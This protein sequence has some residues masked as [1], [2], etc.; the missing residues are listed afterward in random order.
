M[1]QWQGSVTYFM[2]PVDHVLS[3]RLMIREI[4]TIWKQVLLFTRY[5]IYNTKKN[6]VLISKNGEKSIKIICILFNKQGI[7]TQ[8]FLTIFVFKG[9]EIIVCKRQ[10]I[11]FRRMQWG[12]KAIK[13]I[14]VSIFLVIYFKIIFILMNNALPRNHFWHDKKATRLYPY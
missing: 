7:T 9:N 8:L 14:K 12:E 3:S 10:T 2:H 5:I 13:I 11:V 6:L 4:N 1:Y